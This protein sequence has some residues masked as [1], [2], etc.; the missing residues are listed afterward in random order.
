MSDTPDT[1]H[2]CLEAD[3]LLDDDHLESMGPQ[4][5]VDDQDLVEVGAPP[6]RLTP[7]LVLQG[8]GVLLQAPQTIVQRA[9]QLL[10]S[11]DPD[12]GIR[13][14]RVC[15]DLAPST[16]CDQHLPLFRYCMDAA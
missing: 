15:A 13:S 4:R 12:D 10:C 16:G 9:L 3:L 11:N 1:G 7:A 6:S 8:V 14:R 5:S 2:I